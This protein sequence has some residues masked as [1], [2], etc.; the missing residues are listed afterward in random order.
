MIAERMKL[1]AGSQTSGMRN[2]AR[3]LSAEGVHVVNFAAG[4]LDLD[5]SASI[6]EAARKAID[7]HQTQYSDTLGIKALREQ[8][9]RKVTEKTGLAYTTDEVGF[10]AG[11][12]QAL[13]NAVFVAFQAGDE[14][15]I[16]APYWVTFPEQGRLA[17]ATPV[18][19][20]T[21]ANDF[22]IDPVQLSS[23]L[24]PRTRGIILNTPH[25]PTGAV[26]APSA[27]Q[28]IARLCLAHGIT[29]IFDECYDQLV[30]APAEHVN[31]VKL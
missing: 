3:K 21:T 12:K 15:L 4:E 24:T 7:T 20:E 6:K 5:T 17:G 29:C 27:L 25:N 19:L 1:L 14:V 18:V 23:R 28:A 22:Q 9:A 13:F 30:Y 16:P 8:L 10:T 2:R 26:Y 31:I 11:A